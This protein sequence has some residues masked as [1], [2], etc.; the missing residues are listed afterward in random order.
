MRCPG[1]RLRILYLDRQ[2]SLQ[3]ACEG[4][5]VAREP[6]EGEHRLRCLRGPGPGPGF[7]KRRRGRGQCPIEALEKDFSRGP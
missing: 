6:W 2:I 5:G 3:A 7:T 4:R 1:P